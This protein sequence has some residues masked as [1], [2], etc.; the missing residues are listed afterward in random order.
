M[1]KI[2]IITLSDT[3][4]LLL[5]L[6]ECDL[7]LHAGDF[8]PVENH[9]IKYQNDWLHNE[10]RPWLNDLKCDCYIQV[11]GNHDL[12]FEK[13]PELIPNNFPCKFLI[14]QGFEFNGLKIWGSP[15]QLVF[16]NWAFNLTEEK[17]SEKWKLIPD[18]IDILLLH[19][20][21]YGYGD[22][23]VHETDKYGLPLQNGPFV[24]HC[25]SKSLIKRIKE[26]K[27][28]ITIFGHIH[29]GNGVYYLESDEKNIIM[30]NVSV[31]DGNY[32]LVNKPMMFDL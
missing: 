27:P 21:S 1:K 14:D 23:V 5:D 11:P 29:E 15:W 20:P 7:I 2:K 28:K 25:G 19:G 31:M 18:N 17:L 10:F 13:R 24:R 30:A 32:N 6:P 9:S 16:G 3:H 22:K 12:L 26:I 8:L 4:G